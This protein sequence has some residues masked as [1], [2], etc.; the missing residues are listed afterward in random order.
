MGADA[1]A[2]NQV[3]LQTI[4]PLPQVEPP[5]SV[6]RVNTIT[7]ATIVGI[8]REIGEAFKERNKTRPVSSIALRRWTPV[9]QNTHSTGSRT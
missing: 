1:G 2:G 9:F 7:F 4:L 3:Q 6:L 5:N 8:V